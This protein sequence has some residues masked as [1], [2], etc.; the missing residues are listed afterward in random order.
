[1]SIQ[2]SL[3]EANSI[4]LVCE[5]LEFM[6]NKLAEKQLESSISGD[7]ATCEELY[8]KRVNCYQIRQELKFS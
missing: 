2:K 5:A 3:N 7:E 4:D 1:M 8:A 6:A